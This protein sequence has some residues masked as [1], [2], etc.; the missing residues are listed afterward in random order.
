MDVPACVTEAGEIRERGRQLQRAWCESLLA[1]ESPPSDSA[2]F[3]R[4]F[5]AFQT[6]RRALVVAGWTE[7][8]S[9]DLRRRARL[10]A[11]GS[12]ARAED[13]PQSDLDFA[14]VT[15]A[16]VPL[17]DAA[18]EIERFVRFMGPMGFSPCMGHVMGSNPRWFGSSGAWLERIRS[19][20]AF[21]DWAHARYLYMTVDALP[22]EDAPEWAPVAAAVREILAGSPFLKWQMAHLGI[23]G[24]V[25]VRALGGVR[26]QARGRERVFAVKERFLAPLIHALRL[27]SLHHGVEELESVKRASALARMGALGHLDEDRLLRALWFGL[28]LRA[29]RHAECW[30]KGQR[31][32]VDLVFRSALSPAWQE[33][34]E[35]HLRT[36]HA[37]ERLV[38]HAFSR[39]RGSR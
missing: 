9:P 28:R 36:V 13:L 4:W 17:A 23:R 35:E 11:L 12:L 39:P 32:D 18:P 20:A 19:Y 29:R 5:T 10:I 25:G 37:L 31:E 14:L 3:Q 1:D 22:L 15:E 38:C 8:V 7:V 33:A 34:L 26:W 27:L 21:P 24:T 6:Q 16:H 2:W 30:L